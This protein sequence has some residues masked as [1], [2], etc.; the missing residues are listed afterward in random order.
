MTITAVDTI[1]TGGTIPW[2][3]TE[4]AP[5]PIRE[6]DLYEKN[7]YQNQKS[8][9]SRN[10]PIYKEITNSSKN[11]LW[12]GIGTSHAAEILHLA[13]IHPE[14]LTSHI[15]SKGDIRDM[16][17]RYT[18]TRTTHIRDRFL[19]AIR[20]FFLKAKSAEYCQRVSASKTSKNTF[21]FSPAVTWYYNSQFTKVYRKGST[22]LPYLFTIGHSF[23]T[24][25]FK[26]IARS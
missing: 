22:L 25:G 26:I 21:E 17:I 10:T 13:N 5:C 14:T 12:N 8:L 7:L 1:A 11:N 4:L 19:L 20:Q 23:I 18:A 3:D 6:P 15:F 16:F 2:Y 9:A 24:S